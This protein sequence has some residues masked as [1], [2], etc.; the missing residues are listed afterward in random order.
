MRTFAPL[1]RSL[2]YHGLMKTITKL[3]L[4]VMTL[5]SCFVET[6]NR[7]HYHHRDRAVIVVH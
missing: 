3:F 7:R 5:S 4:C 6:G 2:L 1:A